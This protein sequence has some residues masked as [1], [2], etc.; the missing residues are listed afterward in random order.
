MKR[1]KVSSIQ[2]LTLFIDEDDIPDY[3]DDM[4]K[5]IIKDSIKEYSQANNYSSY[6]PDRKVK[7]FKQDDFGSFLDYN[8]FQKY[9]DLLKK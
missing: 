2:A 1:W 3:T 7:Y 5:K 9:K 8:D 6:D 4:M